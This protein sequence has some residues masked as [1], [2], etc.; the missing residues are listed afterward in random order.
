MSRRFKRE[1]VHG[2][3]ITFKDGRFSVINIG[4]SVV[5]SVSIGM[6]VLGNRAVYFDEVPY[7]RSGEELRAVAHKGRVSAVSGNLIDGGSG[8]ISPLDDTDELLM[9]YIVSDSM[10]LESN[11]F[12][13]PFYLVVNYFHC[14]RPLSNTV[15]LIYDLMVRKVRVTGMS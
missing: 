5:H 9:R 2:V 10:D 3:S 7:L 1:S 11:G 15:N 13:W 6:L 14:G 4:P 8:A 12:I